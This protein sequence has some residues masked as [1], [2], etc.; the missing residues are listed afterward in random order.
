MWC[1]RFHIPFI[2]IPCINININVPVFFSNFH[3]ISLK[4]CDKELR[5]NTP[6]PLCDVR[7]DEGLVRLLLSQLWFEI[8]SSS[9][10]L[11]C[12][13][14]LSDGS[15]PKVPPPSSLVLLVGG[16]HTILVVCMIMEW[17]YENIPPIQSFKGFHNLTLPIWKSQGG[18]PP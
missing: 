13:F 17:N 2:I 6:T 10:N 12:M 3:F 4:K 7:R 5:F 15:F 11:L 18:S 16:G 8:S 1:A 9:S 14:S